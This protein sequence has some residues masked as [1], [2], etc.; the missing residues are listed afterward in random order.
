MNA[1]YLVVDLG[2]VLF[3]FD[4]AHRL[5]QLARVCGLRAAQIDALLWGSGFSADCDQGRYASAAQVRAHI[6]TTVG[7]GGTDDELDG[8]WCSAYLP[9]PAV[10]DVVLRHRAGMACA[11]FTNNGPLEEEALTRRHPDFFARFDQVFFSHRLGHRKPDPA[12]FAAVAARLGAV[13]HDIVFID[14]S[15]ANVAAA[16]M[17]GWRAIPFRGPTDLDRELAARPGTTTAR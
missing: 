11:V 10:L 15:Q 8:A 3:H 6:R 7:F 5:E 13:G 14:D 9:N 17:A 4:H 12:A 16:R 1:G 2:R